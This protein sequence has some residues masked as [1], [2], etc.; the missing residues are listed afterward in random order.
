VNFEIISSVGLIYVLTAGI[1]AVHVVL[2]KRN[3]GAAV[4]WLA[5]IVL[6]PFFGVV[7]YT[8]FGINRM[9]GRAVLA[10]LDAAER[11]PADLNPAASELSSLTGAS[12]SPNNSVAPL[13]DGDQAYPAMLAAIKGAKRSV[14]LSSYIFQHDVSGRQFVQTLTDAHH[15][16][17]IVRVLVDGIG[18]RY[19]FWRS[20]ADR[21]LSKQGV[22][23]ARFL[24]T[25]SP[26]D[27]R[28]INL[29]NHRKVMVVDGEH[30]F[31]G[32]MNIRHG[33]VLAQAKRNLTRDIHFRVVGPVVD[34][35]S[36]V[37]QSDWFF[38]T[39]EVLKLDSP[40]SREKNSSSGTVRCRVLVDGPDNNYEKLRL[41]LMAAINAAQHQIVIVTPYFLPNNALL[42]ALHLATLRGVSVQVMLPRR[43]NLR[44]VE[45]AMRANERR[46]LKIGIELR[47]SEAPFDHSKLFLVDNHWTMIGS[48]N[49]DARSLDLNFEINLECVDANLNEQM[50]AV[51]AKKLDCSERV[52]D[53]RD[54]SIFPRLRNNFC[55]LFSPYL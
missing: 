50:R 42:D 37:F 7:L 44:I 40:N 2:N 25:T 53:R 33:N 23:T 28:F 11:R 22:P 35:I 14:L 52:L 51:Y 4:S 32:G 15:R 8:L 38:A 27:V 13:M 1:A 41:A 39:N 6:S 29:R 3:E 47:L 49:W 48:S 12:L 10:H 24:S 16:G 17:V 36:A 46:W 34:Q 55:R 54:R 20:R 43:S 45:W 9:R 5:V 26:R 19:G 30:A 31:I 21:V 18:A